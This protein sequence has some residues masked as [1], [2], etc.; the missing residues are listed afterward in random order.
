MKDNTS[1][2]DPN[3]MP[4]L[5]IEAE[6][7]VITS[8]FAIFAEKVRARL[9]EFNTNLRT[10]EDFDQ[11][12]AD[13]KAI[14]GAEA[15]LKAAKEK[16]LAD[17]EELNA[18]FG[19]LDS[20]SEELATARL[21]LTKQIEAQKAKLKADI[22]NTSLTQLDCDPAMREGYRGAMEAA[23][24]GKKSFATMREAVRIQVK[25][26]NDAVARAKK[27]IDA[28]EAAN[29]T[30]TMDRR[31]LEVKSIE[32]LDGELRRRT[33]ALKAQAE[34]QRLEEEAVTQRAAAEKARADLAEANKPPQAPPMTR[35][36]GP[37]RP[38]GEELPWG[39]SPP[40]AAPQVTGRVCSLA[41]GSTPAVVPD[42]GDDGG[43]EWQGFRAK[44]IPAFGVLKSAREALLHVENR[45]AAA[46]FAEAVNTAWEVANS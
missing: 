10:D 15:S 37:A 11:A 9:G 7:K 30:V 18:L 23:I 27:A 43:R 16:A 8:N 5:V 39:S 29:N 40:P 44:V 42:D 4:L 33:D 1:G 32:F 13:A 26:A 14:A 36:A 31:E 25:I 46:R 12:A 28:F 21:S 41:G 20:L 6:G 17:A 19:Q 38:P 22:I 2:T 34:R 24:K 35:S 3:A 45:R